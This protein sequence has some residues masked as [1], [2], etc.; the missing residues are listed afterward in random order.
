MYKI[1]HARKVMRKEFAKDEGFR[2]TYVAN[3]AM[4]IYDNQHTKISQIT[5][6]EIAEQLINLMFAK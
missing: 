4:C 3:I 1:K 6:T 5:C 2:E